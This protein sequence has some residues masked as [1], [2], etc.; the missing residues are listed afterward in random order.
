MNTPPDKVIA[1]LN[2]TMAAFVQNQVDIVSMIENKSLEWIPSLIPH[3]E[4]TDKII[5][6]ATRFYM[7]LLIT[8]HVHE[9]IEMWVEIEDYASSKYADQIEAQVSELISL[10]TGRTYQ[11]LTEQ[12]LC[13]EH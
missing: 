12:F 7:H 4:Y 1:Y 2:D 6:Q 8:R 9:M 5:A 13:Q 11:E 10:C 3:M